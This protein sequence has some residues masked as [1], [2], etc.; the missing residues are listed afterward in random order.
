LF[1]T[2][3]GSI[4]GGRRQIG[5]GEHRLA[6]QR[7]D[8]GFIQHSLVTLHFLLLALLGG[9]L[10]QAAARPHVRTIDITGG[11]EQAGAFFLGKLSEH[12]AVGR[13]AFEQFGGRTQLCG[14]GNALG[15]VAMRMFG[16]GHQI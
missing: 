10:H 12:G 11:F 6:A 8:A 13:G 5:R 3:C 7:A 2:S 14:E 1:S 15:G 9:F 16:L 4:S